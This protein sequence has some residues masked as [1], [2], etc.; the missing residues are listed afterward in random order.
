MQN[1]ETIEWHARG[2]NRAIDYINA[3]LAESLALDTLAALGGFSPC[4]FHRVFKA[5]VGETH[6]KHICRLRLE[7][8]VLLMD[9]GRSLTE[10]ALAVGFSS[11][12]RFAEAFK[13]QY[14]VTPRAYRSRG[15]A[16]IRK[17]P[18]VARAAA[19][20]TDPSE[21]K[22]IPFEIREF[23][24]YRV[25]YA[26][27]IGG[28]DFTIGFAWKKLMGWARG[29]GYLST[30]SLRIS[31]SWDDPELTDDGKLRYDACVTVPDG[32]EAEGAI[33]IRTI[34]GGTFAVF[35]Y[36]GPQSGLSDFYDRI[37]R[38]LLESPK[39]RLADDQGFRVHQETVPEQIMG[40]YKNELRIPLA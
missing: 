15:A 12:A 19:G 3:H 28:Y 26:R 5:I 34:P 33:G 37:Y 7:R 25:A 9:D 29:K 8:A 22:R 27:H 24:G 16:S 10:I 17:K 30:D 39:M 1:V 23:P 4:H 32:A 6:Q 11:P 40:F 13:A 31:Q 35:R 36:D 14:G 38:T 21:R 18:I 20:D 2:V